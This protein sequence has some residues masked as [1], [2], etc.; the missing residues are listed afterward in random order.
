MI[1]EGGPGRTPG[2]GL[3]WAVGRGARGSGVLGY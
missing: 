1:G 3:A 2:R